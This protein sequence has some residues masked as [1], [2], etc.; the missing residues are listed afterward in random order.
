VGRYGGEKFLLILPGIGFTDA[1]I[2]A[3]EFLAAIQATRISHE[4]AVIAVTASLGVAV[5]FPANDEALIQTA[6][7]ALF[8]AK[9]SGRNCVIAT[10][11]PPSRNYAEA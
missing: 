7:L 6:D 11:I 4:D 1:R 2:R 5:G 8:H 3:E 10:E 9:N